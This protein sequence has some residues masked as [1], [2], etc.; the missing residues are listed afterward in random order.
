MTLLPI[1]TST[2]FPNTREKMEL[3]QKYISLVQEFGKELK[4]RPK[5]K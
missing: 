1:T 5:V 2:E 3:P 4:R